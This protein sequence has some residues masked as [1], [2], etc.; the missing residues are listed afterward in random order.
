VGV[1]Y[2]I[3]YQRSFSCYLT[4]SSHFHTF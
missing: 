2:I 1:G 4:S 3:S